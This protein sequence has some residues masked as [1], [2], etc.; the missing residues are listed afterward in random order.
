MTV[1]S[2]APAVISTEGLVKQFR[3]VDAVAGLDLHVPRGGVYGFLGPNGAGKTTTIRILVGLVRPTRGSASLF[4]LPVRPGAAVLDRV[5]ALVERPAFYP[6]LSAADNLRVL[7]LARG[8]AESRLVATIPEAL[9]RVGLAEAAK[10]KAGRFST[11]MRQRLGIA[12]ALLDRPELVILDEPANG[13]DPNGVVD[14]RELIAGLARDGTTVFLSSHV[15][16]EVEQLC[17][18]VAILQRGR[19]IAEGETQAMLQQGERLFVRFDDAADAARARTAVVAAWPDSV[20]TDEGPAAFSLAA[21]GVRGSELV[22]ALAAAGGLPGRGARAPPVA[23]GRVHRADGRARTRCFG[24]GPGVIGLMRAELLRLRRRRSLQVIVL[25]VPILVGVTF[26][27]GYN[28]VYEQ[29]PFDESAF[30]QEM[31]DGGCCIGVPPEELEQLL[32]ESV[33]SQ[34][35]MFAQLEES[36]RFVRATYA[37]PYSLVQVLGSGTFVLLALILL[38]ATTIGDEFGWATIRTS[39]VASSRRRRFLLVRLGAIAVA[40]LLI[41]G[42]LLVVGALLPLLLDIPRSKLPATL[43][44]FDGGAFLVLLGG[45]LVAGVLVIAFAALTTLLFR[46]GA[47]ALVAVPVWVAIEAALLLLLLRFPNFGGPGGLTQVGDQPPPPPPDAWL[48]DAFPLRGLTTLTQTASK[49]ASGLPGYMG[50][51]VGRDVAV[52]A[53]PITSFT[54]LAAILLVLA[55]RRFSRMD[56]VE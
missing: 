4:G 43:P 36:Q 46:N 18:R 22:R 48:L 28:S 20:P 27:L 26:V 39:L 38:T 23:R 56:I 52:A 10:R 33:K 55:F 6:Y 41:F 40:G 5:G 15:L 9:D 21:A 2:A 49:A 12:G 7:G 34:R 29:P 13:L 50:E 16:P 11:G 17:H 30:R 24:R 45:E 31:L 54:I 35:E 14:V 19:V 25:A 3:D 32:D 44:S 8:I 47:L 1:E 51:V 37:F 42:M 53:V